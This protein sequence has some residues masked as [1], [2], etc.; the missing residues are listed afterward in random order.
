MKMRMNQFESLVCGS[1]HSFDLSR[2]GYL[3]LLL[4][5]NPPSYAKELF[6]ARRRVCEAGFYD[7][8]IAALADAIETH[9]QPASNSFT[10]LDAG[11]GEGSHLS[12]LSMLLKNNKEYFFVGVDISKDS[13]RLATS[14]EADVLWC[15]ADLAG[16]PF[17]DESFD[18]ILN[19]LSPANYTEFTRLL[20]I[21][22]TVFKAIPGPHYLKEIREAVYHG[23]AKNEYSGDNIQDYFSQKLKVLDIRNINYSFAANEATL[24]DIIRMTP[25]TRDVQSI[26]EL[27]L[28]I[29]KTI[30]VD[31]NIL[32][33]R[34]LSSD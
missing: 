19:I 17:Q 3:N 24:P 20:K 5:S 13:I 28:N 11:C 16:L 4:S 14:N 27:Q 8:F 7:P 25:L 33:G 18:V 9:A 10:V 34:R 30:T 23:T 29:P 6:E 32:V 15:V 2:K 31:L 26:E 21:G 1:G 22:G 12:R